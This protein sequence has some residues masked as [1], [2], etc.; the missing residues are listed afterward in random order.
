MPVTGS[1]SAT[2]PLPGNLPPA[3]YTGNDD[4]YE[5]GTGAKCRPGRAVVQST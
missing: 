2:R 4:A 1:G 5:T 3:N